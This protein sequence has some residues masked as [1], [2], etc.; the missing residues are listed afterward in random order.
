MSALMARIFAV[1]L[2]LLII[3]EIGNKK[4]MWYNNL[5]KLDTIGSLFSRAWEGF[6]KR[7]DT[8]AKVFLVPVVF[9]VLGRMLL[10]HE[11]PATI[12]LGF[13]LTIISV[14]ASLAATIALISVF[15]KGTDFA[16]SYRTGFKLFWPSVW[17]AIMVGL[18][19]FGGFVML[20]V[21]GIMLAIA[22][23]LSSF[24]LVL[25]GKRG[26]AAL[27]ASREYIK[28]YW[29][30]VFGRM[31][32]VILIYIAALLILYAPFQLLFGSY[33]GS[34]VYGI[35]IWIITP[36]I[37]SYEYEIFENLRRLKPSVAAESEAKMET[38]FLKVAMV[39]G[40]I[41]WVAFAALIALGIAFAPNGYQ[42]YYGPGMTP[43]PSQGSY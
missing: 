43:P 1:F 24:V 13:L 15:G 35:L 16:A 25:D 3:P 41:G 22:L 14:I 33:V 9:I 20:I 8:V 18:A 30:A 40:I 26:L 11:T 42:G 6:R 5:M 28:G 7:F 29:W 31:L 39:L 36:F 32:L 19:V 34:L 38:S 4:G 10:S 17:I 21:P 23:G 27:A 12:A 37:I 2:M